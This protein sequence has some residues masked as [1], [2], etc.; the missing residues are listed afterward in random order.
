MPLLLEQAQPEL[1]WETKAPHS[2]A[3]GDFADLVL[4]VATIDGDTH[5]AILLVEYI[6]KAAGLGRIWG[7]LLGTMT[8][9]DWAPTSKGVFVERLNAARRRLADQTGFE[10]EVSDFYKIPRL[11]AAPP[12]Y[13]AL[14]VTTTD[15]GDASLLG[16]LEFY[17]ETRAGT[18]AVH[19]TESAQAAFVA[20][21]S[22]AAEASMAA[23]GL[24]AAHLASMRAK[25]RAALMVTF[26]H[27]SK[28]PLCLERWCATGAARELDAI[29][30]GAYFT[31]GGVGPAAERVVLGRLDT[32]VQHEDYAVLAEFLRPPPGQPQ[33]G[34]NAATLALRRLQQVFALPSADVLTL[35]SL[36]RLAA[37]MRSR[38]WQLRSTEVQSLG[39][40]ERAEYFI[41]LTPSLA[42]S[43]GEG[44]GAAATGDPGTQSLRRSTTRFD[45][46]KVR[47]CCRVAAPP[48]RPAVPPHARPPPC[49][50]ATAERRRQP[51]ASPAMARWAAALHALHAGSGS[52]LAPGWLRAGSGPAPGGLRVVPH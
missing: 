35:G 22:S 40:M 7:L 12:W 50:A 52:G 4:R 14:S 16:V 15:I 1:P 6:I 23:A 36:G 13:S 33:A 51:G 37:I 11:D 48:L 30:R 41:G 28:W 10:L 9:A 34:R 44:A 39:L 21:T 38:T 43:L 20:F 2:L 19:A 29:E 47:G 5:A 24:P 26:W 31:S 3:Y 27:D 46:A 25:S 42:P 45:D 17:C 18:D 8:P 49:E 32:V